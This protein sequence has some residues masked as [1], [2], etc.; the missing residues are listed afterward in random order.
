MMLRRVASS[1]MLM[2]LPLLAMSAPTA[3]LD[4]DFLEYLGAMLEEEGEWIDP[5]ELVEF[6]E[7]ELLPGELEAPDVVEEDRR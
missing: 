6:E 1:T 2:A 7:L 3:S 5:L 4:L